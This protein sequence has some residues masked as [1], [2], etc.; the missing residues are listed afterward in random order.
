M[1]FFVFS[2]LFLNLKTAY[3]MFGLAITVLVLGKKERIVQKGKFF[4]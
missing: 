2:F 4:N 3:E 1:G